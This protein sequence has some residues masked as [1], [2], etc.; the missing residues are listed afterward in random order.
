[1]KTLHTIGVIILLTLIS[2]CSD[3]AQ[4]TVEILKNGQQREEIMTAIS[5]DHEM[6]DDMIGHMMESDNAIQLMQDDQVMMGRLM[7]KDNVKAVGMMN[8]MMGG[9]MMGN[10]HMMNMIRNMGKSHTMLMHQKE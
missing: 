5:N 9:M 6:M 7:E 4:I 1:M 8:N 2:G 10:E 3:Q